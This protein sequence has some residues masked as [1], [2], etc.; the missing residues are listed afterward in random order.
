[1]TR[2]SLSRQPDERVLV[3]D[4]ADDRVIA[5]AELTAYVREREV[6]DPAGYGTT[7]PGATSR[8]WPPWYGLSAATS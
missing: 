5:A 4:G 1:M 8:C 6:D 3:V 7:L 2:I